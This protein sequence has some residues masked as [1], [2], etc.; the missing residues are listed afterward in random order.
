MTEPRASSA[1]AV[2]RGVE[3]RSAGIATMRSEVPTATTDPAAGDMRCSMSRKMSAAAAEAR[4][5]AAHM[6]AAATK[7]GAAAATTT[8]MGATAATANEMSATAATANEM[9]ATTATATATATATMS[10]TAATA[11]APGI[12][13][14][15]QTKGKA[16]CGRACCDF[17]HDMTS[18]SGPNAGS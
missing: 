15:R 7:M 5:A 1:I 9:S 16:Y 12:S 4:T 10:D 8:K 6:N 17:P 2:G 3:C 14:S 18:S 11:T 13:N